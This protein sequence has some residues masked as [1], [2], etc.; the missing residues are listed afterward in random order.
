MGKKKLN[1]C[2]KANE[3]KIILESVPFD[4]MDEGHDEKK[5]FFFE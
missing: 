3:R 2:W 1:K 4:E 5:Y